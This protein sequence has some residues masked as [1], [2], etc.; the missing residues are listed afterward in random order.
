MTAKEIG[1]ALVA[2]GR[3]S[4]LTNTQ[5]KTDADQIAQPKPH[6]GHAA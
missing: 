3:I 1:Q 6:A 5:G 4:L 2:P